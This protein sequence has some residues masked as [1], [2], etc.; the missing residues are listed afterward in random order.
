MPE[1]HPTEKEFL[2][3][4]GYIESLVKGAENIS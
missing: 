3:P 4:I 1:Y 2:D